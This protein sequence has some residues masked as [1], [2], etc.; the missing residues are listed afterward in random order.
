M[1]WCP[2]CGSEYR[3]DFSICA[4]CGETLVS[5]EPES[6]PRRRKP[7]WFAVV[8]NL[9]CSVALVIATYITGM[10]VTFCFPENMSR[11]FTGAAFIG[12]L[13]LGGILFALLQ[14]KPRFGLTFIL[15]AIPPSL[16]L[17]IKF[18]QDNRIYQMLPRY[19]LIQDAIY[20]IGYT[21]AASGIGAV[22]ATIAGRWFCG[23]GRKYALAL[24]ATILA[25]VST[26]FVV[27]WLVVRLYG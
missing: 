4:D 15:W 18:I 13:C 5:D 8:V 7:R 23:Q 2:K 3:N 21:L 22:T 16:I 10:F 17:G 1:P 9:I 12:V 6:S 27:Y 19:I 20:W 26:P 25:F 11:P 14:S 24:L